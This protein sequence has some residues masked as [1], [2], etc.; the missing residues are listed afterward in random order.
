[1]EGY[2]QRLLELVERIA[3]ANEDLIK[4]A[5]EEQ[6]VDQQ[7]ERV[8][9]KMV[10]CPHCGAVDPMTETKQA[11]GKASEFVLVTPCG[12]C[13]RTIYLLPIGWQVAGTKEN[14]KAMMERREDSDGEHK[15]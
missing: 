6:V 5:R 4:L 13:G 1:M 14:A 11:S 8:V 7:V 15:D 10:M 3:V 2:E 9:A 12:E